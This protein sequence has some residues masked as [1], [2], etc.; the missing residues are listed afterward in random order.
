LCGN[1][2]ALLFFRGWCRAAGASGRGT[3]EFPVLSAGIVPYPGEVVKVLAASPEMEVSPWNFSG[4]VVILI[5]RQRSM[6]PGRG[7]P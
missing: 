6:V 2:G 4:I 1:N 5:N 3:A 7:K